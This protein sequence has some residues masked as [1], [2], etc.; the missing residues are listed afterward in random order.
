MHH[1]LEFDICLLHV[2]FYFLNKTYAEYISSTWSLRHGV[3]KINTVI[4]QPV[5][6]YREQL[7]FES[8]ICRPR[9][10]FDYNNKQ[11]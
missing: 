9:R 8:G 4:A 3:I 10:N 5:E 11:R 6:G 2:F 7:M 1:W